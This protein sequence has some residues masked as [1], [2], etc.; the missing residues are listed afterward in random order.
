MNKKIHFK[1]GDLID[2]RYTY[3]VIQKIYP[4]KD[5]NWNYTGYDSWGEFFQFNH[6]DY[7]KD[8]LPIESWPLKVGVKDYKKAFES[9]KW[10]LEQL[11][12][13]GIDIQINKNEK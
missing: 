2:L 7:G 3:G 11:K 4:L 6:G 5:G 8:G 12:D 10:K 1:E 13:N 9:I